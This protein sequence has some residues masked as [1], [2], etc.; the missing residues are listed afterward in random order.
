MSD[1]PTKKAEAQVV[2]AKAT[3]EVAPQ[4]EGETLKGE[5]FDA[6]RAMR[7]IETLRAEIKE[8][9]PKAKLADELSEAEKQRKEAEMTEL[10]KLEAKLKAAEAKLAAAELTEL[11]RSVA[12]EVGLPAAFA[13]RLQGDTREALLEDA[14]NLLEALPKPAPPK[15]PAVSP[16]SP[17]AGASVEKTID[18]RRGEVYGTNFDPL[19]P[20]YALKHGGGV[21]W[22]KGD[23]KQ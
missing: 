20:G 23:N 13:E 2:E 12:A 18:Q 7:T 5:P 15:A 14:K 11:K 9:K 17:G 19:D 21:V 4:P 22:T 3:P 8:L 10:Q 16:T 6:D 1:E